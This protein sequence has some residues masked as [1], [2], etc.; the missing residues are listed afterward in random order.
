M[1]AS[2]KPNTQ[3]SADSGEHGIVSRDEWLAARRELLR[4]EKE[5]TRAGD[6]LAAERRA[7]PWVR[8]EKTYDFEGPHGRQTLA[9]L[10]AGRSQLI[11]YH[12][13]FEPGWSEGCKSCS[14]LA[15]HIDGANLHLAHHDV[16]LL[17]VARAPWREL[18]PFKQR[19]G[20]QFD[21]VSSFGSD[22]N[23]DYHVSAS[24]A[25]IAAGRRDYNFTSSEGGNGDWPGVSVFYK[26]DRGEIFHTYSAYAR[27]GDMLLG[28]HHY[29]DLTP[30][31]RAEAGTMDW[32][33]H[34][35]KYD[36]AAANK[37]ACCGAS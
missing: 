33:R 4:K 15:D 16:T 14:F 13:M 12:F 27:G 3:L 25:E 17:A 6:R 11:V 2:T 18:Q 8:V 9:D 19:M 20:W 26:N 21:W 22:F 5:Y 1:A 28:T 7:L 31:G 23:Y 32:V 29:L 30:K 36:S 35:D 10:F 24:P 37:A 34:H